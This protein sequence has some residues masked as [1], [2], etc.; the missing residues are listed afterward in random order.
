MTH[1]KKRILVVEDDP[2]VRNVISRSLEK[3]GFTV[4]QAEHAL[5]AI[6]ALVQEGVDLVL[7]DIRMPILNG[8]ELVRQL[9]AHDDTRHVPIVAVTGSDEPQ[10]R[11][12]AFEA[13][14]VGY[15]T[16]P[17]DVKNFPKQIQA[18]IH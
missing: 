14:C 4:V 11:A 13:G 6:C 10:D 12:N 9:K 18:F 15:I 5:A 2:S 8:V 17:I 16:K 3:G 7:V 1:V